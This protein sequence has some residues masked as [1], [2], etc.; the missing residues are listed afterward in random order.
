MKKVIPFTNVRIPMFFLSLLLLAAGIT[1]T[2]L[3]SGFNVGIDFTGGLNKQF[4]IAPTAL[5][6]EYTGPGSA[7]LDLRPGFLL[8]TIS[9]RGDESLRFDLARYTELDGLASVLSALDGMQ[10]DLLG[11]PGTP[12]EQLIPL[13]F[14]VDIA[15][16]SLVINRR[17]GP[18]EELQAPIDR[19]RSTLEPVGA[20]GI[21][22]VGN[23]QN[24]EFLMKLPV[25]DEGDRDFLQKMDQEATELLTAQF[26][27]NS[28]LAKKIEFV[29]S[30]FSVDLIR[31]AIWSVVVALI[32]ILVYITF[33]FRIIFAI[34]AVMA[35]IHDVGIMIGLIGALQLEVSSTTVAAILTIIGYSLND[36]IVVFDRVRENT[37]L[38]PEASR[39]SIINTSITQSLSRTTITSLTTLLAV[40]AIYVFGT[41]AIKDFAFNLIIGVVIGTYSSIFI[42]APIVLAW[43]N[44]SD[45]RKRVRDTG[46]AVPSAP[47][48]VKSAA[49]SPTQSVKDADKG[50]LKSGAAD[51]D[52]KI[53]PQTRRP[54]KKKRKRKKKN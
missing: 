19:V 37:G 29:G 17:L 38:M 51:T 48:T 30:V 11:P 23:P 2:L 36:T 6:V 5:S 49:E 13:S 40:V 22:V 4:Q 52:L 3:R 26:G 42:A 28:V 1:V 50:A 35:L 47:K 15:I 14:P 7:T 25:A 9:E 53:V 46:G 27:P 34:A 12:T 39:D 54:P 31:G 24:Q 20:V 8:L 44:L 21:Q 16:D 18:E 45:R 41:G 10:V 32:L 43:Q 33:R